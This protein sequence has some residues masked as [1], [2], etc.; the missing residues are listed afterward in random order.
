MAG[1][2][3]VTYLG[4]NTTPTAMDLAATLTQRLGT[5]VTFDKD[6]SPTANQAAI[7]AGAAHIV[8]MC[9]FAT[10]EGLDAGRLALDIVAAPVFPDHD[11]PTYRSVI[12]T[13][14]D[15]GAT[16]VD[17]L[18][19]SRLAINERSSWSGY[20]AL[21]IHLAQRGRCETFFG[22]IA[23]TGGHGASIEAVLMGAADAAA[24][25]DTI[26]GQV[27]G[28]DPRLAS[29][30]VIDRTQ[31]WPAP[32]FSLSRS[33]DPATRDAL[34]AALPTLS[35]RGLDGIRPATSADYDPIRRGMELAKGVAW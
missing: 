8:W 15:A 31:A 10:V 12:I 19:G 33:L 16:S 11:G 24:I 34:A 25:D 18:E 35:P 29:L 3:L 23:E 13:R 27:V 7:G 14:R 2:T 32:P 26:W 4:D 5:P 1:L 17:D 28:M 30:T 20:H 22:S 6:A 21:R 9:G